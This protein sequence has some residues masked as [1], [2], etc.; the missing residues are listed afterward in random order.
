LRRSHRQHRAERNARTAAC[1][2]ESRPSSGLDLGRLQSPL[3][4]LRPRRLPPPRPPQAL[5]RWWRSA[6]R[7][8]GAAPH[9]RAHH[10]PTPPPLPAPPPPPPPPAPPPPAPPPRRKRSDREIFERFPLSLVPTY[11]G[12]HALFNSPGFAAWLPDDLPVVRKT[13]EE[14]MEL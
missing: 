11:P 13:L 2:H 5:R 14:I 8:R 3:E 4:R 6:G 10:R 12:D 7:L 9:R 1:R